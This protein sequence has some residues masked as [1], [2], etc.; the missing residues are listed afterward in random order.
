MDE[1]ESKQVFARLVTLA[2]T[3]VSG[4][5]VVDLADELVQ[6]CLEFLPVSAA[7]ILLDDQQGHLRVLASSTEEM[8]VLELLE[9]QHSEG[10]CYEAFVTGEPVMATDLSGRAGS[11]PTFVPAATA[12]GVVAAFALPLTLRD[13]TIGAL[14][15]FSSTPTE[16]SATQLQVAHAMTS[17]ATLGI[18]NHWTVRRQEL[19]AEQLQTALNSRVVIEQAKGVIAERSS[20]DMATAFELLRSAARGQRRPLSEL[21]AEVAQGRLSPASLIREPGDHTGQTTERSRSDQ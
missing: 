6:S 2:D 17:M 5:D 16:M 15:L 7:G 3:L 21:A 1:G 9:L 10:P 12:R 19:L 18:L 13:R 4:F 20:V 14:N 8:R 11:W